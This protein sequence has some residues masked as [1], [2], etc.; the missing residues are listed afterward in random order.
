MLNKTHVKTTYT[1]ITAKIMIITLVFALSIAFMYGEYLKSESIKTLSKEDAKQTSML[2]F[3]SL[4]SA[5]AKGWNKEEL[6]SIIDRLNNVNNDLKINV[7]RSEVVERNF[8]EMAP[9]INAIE[10]NSDIALSMKGKEVLNLL[11]NHNIEYFYP[12]VAKE[13]CLSCHTKAKKDDVLGVINITYPVTDLK[14]SLNAMINFFIYFILAFSVLLFLILFLEF[15]KYLLKPIK[16][17]VHVINNISNSHDITKRINDID[18]VEEISSMQNVFNNMLDSIEFQFYNDDLTKLP[19]RRKMIEII[20][21]KDYCILMLLNIDNFQEINDLYGHEEGDIIIKE[22]AEFL[23][24]QMDEKSTL[25]KLNADEYGILFLGDFDQDFFNEYTKKL[26]EDVSKTKFEVDNGK[27][28]I[29]LSCTIGIAHGSYSL[30]TNSD[31]ALKLA[32]KRKV[33]YLI[34]ESSMQIEHE[35]EQNLKWTKKIKD[36]ITNDKIVPLFQPIVDCNS[37]KIVKYESL[38]RMVDEKGEYITPIH[39][40]SLA[41]K[42]KLYSELT[43][44]II[45]KT[46]KIF[47]ERSEMVSINLSVEDMLNTEIVSLIKEQLKETQIGE[48]VVFEIIESEGIEN[49]E[50]VVEFINDIKQFGSKISIDDFG[51]GYSNFEYLMKLKIDYIKIDASMIKNVDTNKESAIITETIVDFAN[52]LHIKTIGEFVYSKSVYDKI[53]DIGIDY[54]QGYYFGQPIDLYNKKE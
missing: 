5:M 29:F 50:S 16:N 24:L 35:Y 52:K 10:N 53:I 2:I 18:S 48:R 26:I 25:F 33:H 22:F 8:G 44:I 12:I 3:E 51:T 43:K 27:S 14:V 38:M 6:T 32:K 47:K 45:K 28:N 49:F 19:N 9:S 15:D 39:F 46:F 4:Y 30:L 41:K 31:I 13:N 34:Y 54:A 42:N 23:E 17:F 36:A 7:Y 37:G 11:D 1:K 21:K 40:L 20:D